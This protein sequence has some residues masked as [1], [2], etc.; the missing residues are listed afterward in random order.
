MRGRY[1]AGPE[2]VDQLQ[3]SAEAKQRAKVI[4]QTLLGALRVQEACRVLGICEQRFQQLREEML[5]AAVARLEA[6]PTGRPRRA[7]EPEEISALRQELETMQ[8]ALRVAQV[9]EEI[10]LAMPLA[11]ARAEPAAPAEPEKKTP[12]RPKRRARPGWWKK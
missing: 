12:R 1:P 9:R 4:L 8:L 6:R 5:Q 3:G 11:A 7:A 10:A 2:Y